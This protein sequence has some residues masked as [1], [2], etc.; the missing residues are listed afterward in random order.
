MNAPGSPKPPR[1]KAKPSLVAA[2][3]L[4]VIVLVAAFALVGF[5]N[6]S[7]DTGVSALITGLLCLAASPFVGLAFIVASRGTVGQ[8]I[9][10]GLLLGF[11]FSVLG[12]TGLCFTLIALD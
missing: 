11:G 3:V 4:G 8:S 2:T 9:G 5:R 7:N 1:A 12:L 10:A 6:A